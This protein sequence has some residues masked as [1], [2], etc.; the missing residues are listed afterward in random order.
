MNN[1]KPP[2]RN[3]TQPPM[4]SSQSN[5]TVLS[6]DQMYEILGDFDIAVSKGPLLVQAV[7]QSPEIQQLCKD[8]ERYRWLR[9]GDNDEQVICNG[10]I[11]KSYWY[12]LRAEKLDA[13]IDAAM[14]VKP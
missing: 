10:P 12:L 14:E 1:Q 9:H 11:D 3:P 5:K 4:Q 6:F 2:L 7:L 13:V 8:A